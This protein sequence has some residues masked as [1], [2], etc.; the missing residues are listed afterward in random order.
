M[1][2]FELSFMGREGKLGSQDIF[3]YKKKK[4]FG[5]CKFRVNWDVV[6]DINGDGVRVKYPFKVR[7]F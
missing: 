7:L 2:V 1:T 5:M 4:D 3:Y 6:C